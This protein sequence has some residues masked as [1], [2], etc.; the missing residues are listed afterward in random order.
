MAR[1]QPLWKG[2][3]TLFITCLYMCML[4]H[5]G[6]YFTYIRFYISFVKAGTNFYNFYYMFVMAW[7]YCLMLHLLTNLSVF[8]LHL[9]I[10]RLFFCLSR[11][12]W[13]LDL[14]SSVHGVFLIF[15]GA[16]YLINILPVPFSRITKKILNRST[17]T[18]RPLKLQWVR[19][20]IWW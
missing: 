2:F 6:L 8:K 5:C 18:N 11:S 14:S 4:T 19:F 7:H 12:L 15:V 20:I 1:G 10:F 3:F 17:P 16:A 13:I 9:F